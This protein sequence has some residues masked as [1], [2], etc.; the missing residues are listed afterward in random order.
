VVDLGSELPTSGSLPRLSPDNDVDERLLC[1]MG[2]GPK[3]CDWRSGVPCRL[4][5]AGGVGLGEAATFGRVDWAALTGEGEVI[6]GSAGSRDAFDGVSS[7]SRSF[8]N[9]WDD[10]R[11]GG[12]GGS[13]D[14]LFFFFFC[15][16]FFSPS[17][18]VEF[19]D[20][21]VRDSLTAARPCASAL[22]ASTSF[23]MLPALLR[24][25]GGLVCAGLPCLALGGGIRMGATRPGDCEDM[26]VGVVS[27]LYGPGPGDSENLVEGLPLKALNWLLAPENNGVGGGR[28]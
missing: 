21:E 11:G 19:D 8:L 2:V 3:S 25:T 9:F 27:R 28:S 24:V 6:T 22:K 17:R 5:R 4:G 13:G 20:D 7:S 12:L 18:T 15:C 14:S 1:T 10:F 23:G 16:S 26:E